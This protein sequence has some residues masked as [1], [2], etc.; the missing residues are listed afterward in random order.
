MPRAPP[1]V[2]SATANTSPR[3][4]AFRT[5][6]WTWPTGSQKNV[7][8]WGS[9]KQ[10]FA[11]TYTRL[12]AVSTA[13]PEGRKPTIVLSTIALEAP[14][15]ATTRVPRVTGWETYTRLDAPLVF[16]AITVVNPPTSTVV[17][18]ASLAPS[19]TVKPDPPALDT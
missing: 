17:T 3:L 18:I 14:P 13:M 16:A 10:L 15:T 11:A 2:L 1:G 12:R 9:K 19:I 7:I 5:T 8:R 4:S 6:S